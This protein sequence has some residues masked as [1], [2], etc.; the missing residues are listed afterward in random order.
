MSTPT[1]R[2]TKLL[3]AGD[4][5]YK[6]NDLVD[7]SNWANVQSLISTDYLVKLSSDEISELTATVEPEEAP[8]VKKA[9]VK[10]AAPAKKPVA[11]KTTR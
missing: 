3:S 5:D 9:P 7:A 11:K 1:H 8:V 10:K 6:V 2:V 4:F